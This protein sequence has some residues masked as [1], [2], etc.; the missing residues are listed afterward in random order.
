[1]CSGVIFLVLA[2]SFLNAKL[3]SEEEIIRL[4]FS[5]EEI[6]L[7]LDECKNMRDLALIEFLNSTGARVSEVVKLN[8]YDI[9]LDNIS[10][11][12]H[13]LRC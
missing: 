8:K 5:E 1:M 12:S 11:I 3:D 9:N 6:Q 7:M 13:S 4:P 10:N 2:L